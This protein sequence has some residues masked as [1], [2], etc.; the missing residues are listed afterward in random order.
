MEDTTLVL[1]HYTNSI[2]MLFEG[3]QTRGDVAQEVAV[4]NSGSRSYCTSS[5]KVKS[6]FFSD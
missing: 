1:L 3:G 5:I 6:L 2:E 4:S